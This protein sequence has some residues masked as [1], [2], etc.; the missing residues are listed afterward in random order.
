MPRIVPDLNRAFDLVNYSDR[1]KFISRTGTV[2]NYYDV[3]DCFQ[4]ARSWEG[5]HVIEEL[6][7]LLDRYELELFPYMQNASVSGLGG[8]PT[9]CMPIQGIALLLGAMETAEWDSAT[10]VPTWKPLPEDEP[11]PTEEAPVDDDCTKRLK[12]EIELSGARAREFE[13]RTKMFEA[14]AKVLRA[15]DRALGKRTRSDCA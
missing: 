11:K 1:S 6:S 10:G 4:Y 2:P 14:E 9:S 12:L 5:G 3:L 13:A 15:G 7:H 8:S